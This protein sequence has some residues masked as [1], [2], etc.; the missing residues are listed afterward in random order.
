V[1]ERAALDPG[2]HVAVEVLRVRGAAEHEPAARPAQRLVR[3][4]RDERRVR[5]RRVW[6][7]ASTSPAMC[8]MSHIS[9]A[10]TS[11]ATSPNLAKSISRA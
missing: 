10:P 5:H 7:P 3:R 1:L 11:S 2:E 6:S 4:R 9:T 8:A